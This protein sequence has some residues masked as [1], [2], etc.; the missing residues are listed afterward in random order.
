MLSSVFR[1]PLICIWLQPPVGHPLHLPSSLLSFMPHA[2]VLIQTLLTL[3]FFFPPPLCEKR[4]KS[5]I[6]FSPFVLKETI[7]SLSTNSFAP[8][9]FPV[10][11]LIPLFPALLI[12]PL[13]TSLTTIPFYLHASPFSCLATELLSG[14]ITE[15][16]I[17]GLW[18]GVCREMVGVCIYS[19]LVQW[20]V[21]LPVAGLKLHDF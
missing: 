4:I 15:W 12:T 16:K 7:T 20:L 18:L 13:L 2:L 1:C 19:H 3:Y 11:N 6:T 9:F 21:T 5:T 14:A 8:S 10:P 17:N